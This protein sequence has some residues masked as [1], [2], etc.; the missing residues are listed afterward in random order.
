M[1]QKPRSKRTRFGGDG[2]AVEFGGGGDNGCGDSVEEMDGV[3]GDEDSGDVVMVGMIWRCGCGEMAAKVVPDKDGSD[4]EDANEYIE[5]VLEIVDLFHI[6]NITQDQGLEVP[7]RQILDSK[8]AIPTMT[9]TDV[10]VA[11]QEMA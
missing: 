3:G 10:K 5:K 9:V 4:N 6:P 1:V 7:T 8:G 11:I 2:V